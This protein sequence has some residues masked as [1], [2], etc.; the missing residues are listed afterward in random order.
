[1]TLAN[2]IQSDTKI[3]FVENE[4]GVCESISLIANVNKKRV[5]LCLKE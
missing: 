4:K 3:V 5:V 1:M 2:G